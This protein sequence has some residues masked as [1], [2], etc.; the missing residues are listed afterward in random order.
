MKIRDRVTGIKANTPINVLII[1]LII[2]PLLLTPLFIKKLSLEWLDTSSAWIGYYGSVVSS[3]ATIVGIRLTIN[4]TREQAKEDRRIQYAPQ[5]KIV[6]VKAPGKNYTYSGEQYLYVDREY[7][8]QAI[9]YIV[10]KNIGMGPVLDMYV[11]NIRYKG[12]KL[13]GE[14][15]LYTLE[16]GEKFILMMNIKLYLEI[17]GK[18]IKKSLGSYDTCNEIT[19]PKSGRLQFDINYNDL[20]G[21]DYY[22][23]HEIDIDFNLYCKKEKEDTEWE[24]AYE[25][26]SYAQIKPQEIIKK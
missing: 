9:I 14:Y 26:A 10:I 1:L 13:D 24:Y 21:K 16:V 2:S 18:P 12:N 8:N 6:T 5:L 11:T 15:L 4:Y 22:Y 25:S 20:F 7:N 17:D 3:I 23:H 19:H